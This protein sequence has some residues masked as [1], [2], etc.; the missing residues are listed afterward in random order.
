[1]RG[2]VTGRGFG[3]RANLP[4]ATLQRRATEGR[5]AK[6]HTAKH[7][8]LSVRAKIL[9]RMIALGKASRA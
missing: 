5:R 6:R 4:M 9:A 3:T 1:M 7:G 8:Q 2:G